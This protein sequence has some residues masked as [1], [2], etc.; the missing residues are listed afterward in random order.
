MNYDLKNSLTI[1]NGGLLPLARTATAAGTGIDL[2]GYESSVCVIQ[3]IGAV[4]G[5]SPTCDTRIQDSADNSSFAD[6]AGLAFSTVTAANNYQ[7]LNV[8]P[9][10][11]RRYVRI[12]PIIGGTTPSFTGAYSVIGRK[13]VQ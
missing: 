1:L 5:T 11:V 7:T 3:D 2:K 12:A 4:T 13:Q 6:V 8:D 10:A 9:R